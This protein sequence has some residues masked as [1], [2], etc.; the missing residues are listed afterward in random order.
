MRNKKQ[1]NEKAGIV[2]QKNIP[3]FV[4]RIAG[5]SFTYE[6]WTA[7]YDGANQKKIYITLSAG[8]S[9]DE[10]GRNYLRA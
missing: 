7:N 5:T 9:I 10:E 6:I 2:S 4:K 8:L 1:R 3:L